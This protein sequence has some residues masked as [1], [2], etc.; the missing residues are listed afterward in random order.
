MVDKTNPGKPKVIVNPENYEDMVKK[1]QER[2]AEQE[3]RAR[4]KGGDNMLATAQKELE[5]MSDRREHRPL[6]GEERV[7]QTEPKDPQVLE[8]RKAVTALSDRIDTAVR[9]SPEALRA[10]KGRIKP[11]GV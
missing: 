4:R 9:Q 6:K 7:K 1:L 10:L 3:K 5:K 2:E 8:V 11:G